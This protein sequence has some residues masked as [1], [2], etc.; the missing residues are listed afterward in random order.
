MDTNDIMFIIFLVA[1]AVIILEWRMKFP[2]GTTK[3][4]LCLISPFI[5][6]VRIYDHKWIGFDSEWKFMFLKE[7]TET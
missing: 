2:L 6:R 7:T 3:V 5:K 1:L 4:V